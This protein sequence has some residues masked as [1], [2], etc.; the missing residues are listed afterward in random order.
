MHKE[1]LK[2]VDVTHLS[3]DIFV[4]Y[5]FVLGYFILIPQGQV[6]LDGCSY[7]ICGHQSGT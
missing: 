5:T 3:P 1:K 2:V 7:E 4:I 6:Q